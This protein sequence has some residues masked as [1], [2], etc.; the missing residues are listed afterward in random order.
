MAFQ[1][2]ITGEPAGQ[3][4]LA[5]E[6]FYLKDAFGIGNGANATLMALTQEKAILNGGQQTF[7][8][9]LGIATATEA[10]S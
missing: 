6:E 2:E 7:G 9:S 10:A 8:Q 4:S 3:G 1:I 5:R